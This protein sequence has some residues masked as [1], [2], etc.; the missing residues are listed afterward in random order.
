MQSADPVRSHAI[1]RHIALGLVAIAASGAASMAYQLAW[2]RTLSLA[3]GSST[4][5]FTA[6]L[7]AFL[8][9]LAGG[10]LIVSRVLRQRRLDLLTFGAL[11]SRSR[12]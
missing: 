1:P 5:A 12:S 3:L 11:G 9:G 10:A 7:T 4:Y 6:M 2:T 8:V